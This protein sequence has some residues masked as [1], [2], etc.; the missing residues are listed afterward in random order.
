MQESQKD[1]FKSAKYG[2]YIKIT[3]DEAPWI[4]REEYQVHLVKF[5]STDGKEF[6]VGSMIAAHKTLRDIASGLT[7]V[8]SKQGNT[9][10]YQS[11]AR[12][13]QNPGDVYGNHR[14]SSQTKGLQ[15]VYAKTHEVREYFIRK[16]IDDI[17]AFIRVAACH[18]SK[19]R[20]VLALLTTGKRRTDGN[21]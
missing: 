18:K 8:Q 1:V 5:S 7:Q 13:L 6:Y 2:K 12:L 3:S 14:L 16:H 21:H 17:P 10:L 11:I 19:E 20:E 15:I 4:N 9:E